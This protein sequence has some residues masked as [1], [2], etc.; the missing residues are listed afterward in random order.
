MKRP[1]S[2][3]AVPLAILLASCVVDA[4]RDV[5][6]AVTAAVD[7]GAVTDDGTTFWS[8]PWP[9]DARL[10]L[11]G[12]P[13]LTGFP[14]PLDSDLFNTY[15]TFGTETSTGYGLTSPIY[16]DL[17]GPTLLPV[18][19]ESL[20]AVAQACDGPVRLVN[21]DPTSSGY[22]TCSPVQWFIIPANSQDPFL[23]P[24]MLI[25]QPIWGFPLDP[26][27][28]YAAYIVDIEAT[29]GFVEGPAPLQDALNGTSSEPWATSYAPL[30]DF[31]SAFPE[32]AGEDAAPAE[33]ST[34]PYDSRW[35]ASAT[36]FTTHDPTAGM[37][38]AA[39]FV[40]SDT[41]YPQWTSD[42]G[43]VDVDEEH[44]QYHPDYRMI[45]GAY[46]ARN[47]QRGEI[48]YATEGGGFVIENGVITPQAVERIPFVIGMPDARYEQPEGGW[49][50]VL[51]SH[52]TG[53]DQ[54]S[55][56]GA[57][58]LFRPGLQA[59]NRGFISMGIP[60]P[61]HGE[62]WP[63]G[64]DLAVDLNSFNF[65]NPESGSS[66]FRQGGLDMLSQVQFVLRYMTGTGE[67]AAAAP[68]LRVDPEN[69]YFLGH[70]QGG[71]TG[72]LAMPFDEHVKGFIISGAGGGLP[73][74][75]MLRE[76]P[77][78]IRDILAGQLGEPVGLALFEQHP[79]VALVGWLGEL[80]DPI[81]YA[82]QWNRTGSRP[83][84]SVL[85]FQG[86]LDEQTPSTTSDAL[87]VAGGLTVARPFR[88]QVPFG[89]ER[90]G[91]EP[92][93]TPYSGNATAADGTDVTLGFAQFDENH[94]V[95]FRDPNA[96]QLWGNFLLDMARNGGPGVLGDE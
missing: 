30:V 68:E 16:F 7:F 94:F 79:A 51:H 47:F 42:E 48:P 4:P 55:H 56:I 58:S 29:D 44:D 52:G 60:Q 23:Q 20:A 54:W 3:L 83:G 12:T 76:D 28:T 27:T 41:E 65:F 13:D 37:A 63:E 53:G 74:T 31:L 92:L 81:V 17:S 95:I 66:M 91:L 32:A 22:G 11:D 72:S 45:V 19:E 86:V 90:R 25:V 61:I 59:S 15:L 78:I 71:L 85:M 38:L 14:N 73:M 39:D 80:T 64:G 77:V 18:W 36:V 89:L 34:L 62:R 33:D 40:K 26:S 50:I 43:L 8:A 75:V 49:P 46:T 35:I 10:D 82:P 6:E 21:V 67:I 69:I 87:A 1:A 96:A 84:V 9:S 57:G 2:P 93:R 5:S 70:S 24:D 88:E